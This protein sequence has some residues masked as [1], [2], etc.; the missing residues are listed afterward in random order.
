[1]RVKVGEGGGGAGRRSATEH[2][3]LASVWSRWLDPWRPLDPPH[4]S[5]STCDQQRPSPVL[6]PCLYNP[7]KLQAVNDSLGLP[8]G[9]VLVL[10]FDLCADYGVLEKAA[11]AADQAFGGA[12]VDYLIHNA[13][14][15]AAM[16]QR[17]A[18]HLWIRF[19]V[20]AVSTVPHRAQPD[21][22]IRPD[23]T[24]GIR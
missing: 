12:G 18:E 14:G 3:P 5:S 6:V 21:R 20:S 8:D 9:H 4:C 7:Q 22:W 1:M 10:P 11:E 19:F 23:L 2:K 24:A 16:Y 17:R 13:G 15:Q